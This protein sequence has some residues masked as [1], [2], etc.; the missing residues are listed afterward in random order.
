MIIRCSPPRHLRPYRLPSSNIP[1]IGLITIHLSHVGLSIIL[2][3]EVDISLIE[4]IV[5]CEG[6]V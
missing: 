5:A 4:G 6:L 1:D 3:L 2:P